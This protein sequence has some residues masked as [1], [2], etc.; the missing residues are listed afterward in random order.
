MKNI[1]A[2]YDVDH[3]WIAVLEGYDGS[4]DAEHPM[5]R[6]N[7]KISAINHLMEQMDYIEG[8]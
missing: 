5:G 8:Q 6:S 1:I 2:S 3:G 4:L 7:T